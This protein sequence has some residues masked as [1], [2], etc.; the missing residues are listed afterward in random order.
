[1][2][3]G[4]RLYDR[5]GRFRIKLGP[6]GFEEYTQFL[7]PGKSAAELAELVRFYTGDP[8]EFDIQLTLKGEE[9]PELP[10]GER[11]ML[12]RLSWTTWLKSKPADATEIIFPPGHERRIPVAPEPPPKRDQTAPLP[13]A[14]VEDLASSSTGGF[15]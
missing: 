12:G 5:A 14:P 6:L 11:G 7:P 1:M 10:L 13:A 9:V 2:L 3:L 4:E 8:L 15:F